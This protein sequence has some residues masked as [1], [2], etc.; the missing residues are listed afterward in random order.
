MHVQIVA[1]PLE[2]GNYWKLSEK[3]SQSKIGTERGERRGGERER[4]R[5]RERERESERESERASLDL[6]KPNTLMIRYFLEFATL[7]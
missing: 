7:V 3:T 5:A 1:C 2:D 6:F 4:E